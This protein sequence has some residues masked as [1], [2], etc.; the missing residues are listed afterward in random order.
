MAARNFFGRDTGLLEVSAGMAGGW[1]KR[2]PAMAR[3]LPPG[4]CSLSFPPLSKGE[5]CLA[6][7][8]AFGHGEHNAFFLIEMFARCEHNSQ[9]QFAGLFGPSRLLDK[10]QA[11]L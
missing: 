5:E 6:G 8:D 2:G 10:P 1:R 3:H 11:V 4:R 7:Q 9:Q